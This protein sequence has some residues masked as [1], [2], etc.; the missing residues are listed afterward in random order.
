MK[1]PIENKKISRS[2]LFTDK[3][4][5]QHYLDWCHRLVKLA[6]D[7]NTMQEELLIDSERERLWEYYRENRAAIIREMRRQ[8]NIDPPQ[9]FVNL[10][11]IANKKGE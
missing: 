7:A 11:C 6:C 1:M 3:E 8:Y 5:Y 4:I 9:D 2:S 10:G